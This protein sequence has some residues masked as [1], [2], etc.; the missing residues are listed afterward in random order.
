[1]IL[2]KQDYVERV[3]ELLSD[4]SKFKVASI[5]TGKEIR[6]MINVRNVYKEV[7][8]QL[9]HKGKISQQTF[10]KL[11]PIGCNQV[12]CMASAMYISPL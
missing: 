9:L 11:D 7:L 2:N 6:H 12:F 10:W 3:N 8:D 1:M 5:K 4:S